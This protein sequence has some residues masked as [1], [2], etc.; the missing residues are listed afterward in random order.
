MVEE[1]PAI[2]GSGTIYPAEVA[3]VAND[4]VMRQQR[5]VSIATYPVQYNPQTMEL[6][7]YESLQVEVTFEAGMTIQSQAEPSQESEAFENLLSQELLNYETA[8]QWRQAETAMPSI[9]LEAEAGEIGPTALPYA[10]P[11]PGWRVKVRKDGLYKLTYTE[12]AD[13]GLPVT[14]LAPSTLKLYNLGNE[15]AIQVNL[16]SDAI[17][18]DGDYLLF[19]GQ[20]KESKYT[21]D[22]VYWLTYGGDPGLRMGSRATPGTAGTPDSYF[23]DQL[24]HGGQYHLPIDGSR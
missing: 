18:N 8:R 20:A 6:T 16:G 21:D 13:A 23:P 7:I 24:H 14:T 1:D 22:N 11:E 17:F 9:Q 3:Q 2:Y 19:Y 4:G 12:M 15:V 5:V 10:P